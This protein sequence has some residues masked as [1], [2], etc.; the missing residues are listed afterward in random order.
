MQ[1]THEVPSHDDIPALFLVGSFFLVAAAFAVLIS[2]PLFQPFFAMIGR[3][4]LLLIRSSDAF[5][6]IC[7]IGFLLGL[8]FCAASRFNAGMLGERGRLR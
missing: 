7:L 3:L 1:T 4:A 5:A 8:P 2:F 6:L